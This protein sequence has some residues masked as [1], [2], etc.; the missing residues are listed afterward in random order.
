MCIFYVFVGFAVFL[1]LVGLQNREIFCAREP[2]LC[3]IFEAFFIALGAKL[4]S[5]VVASW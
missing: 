1:I 2:V 5:C 4:Q 3:C